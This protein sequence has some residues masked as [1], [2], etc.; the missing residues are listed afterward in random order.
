M[1]T[2]SL[3]K[4]KQYLD[5]LAGPN[6]AK[7]HW[8]SASIMA[9]VY[10]VTLLDVVKVVPPLVSDVVFVVFWWCV[11]VPA[12]IVMVTELVAVSSKVSTK[13]VVMHSLMVLWIM[14]VAGGSVVKLVFPSFGVLE[15]PIR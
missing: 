5:W 3:E 10:A 13:E 2:H 12:C 7:W 9:S 8:R 14:V 15:T 4:C 1:D 11:M 6:K